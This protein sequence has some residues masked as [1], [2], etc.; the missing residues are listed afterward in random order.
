MAGG[1]ESDDASRRHRDIDFLCSMFDEMDRDLMV[2]IYEQRQRDVQQTLEFLLLQEGQQEEEEEEDNVFINADDDD[3]KNDEELF[4]SLMT[5]EDRQ[6]MIAEMKFY[7]RMKHGVVDDDEYAAAAAADDDD[8]DDEE[9]DDDSTSWEDGLTA[10]QRE[11]ICDLC[12]IFSIDDREAVC[13]VLIA[14]E[15]DKQAAFEQLSLQLDQFVEH[16]QQ[17][18]QQQ[19]KKRKRKFERRDDL[20]GARYGLIRSQWNIPKTTVQL[21]RQMKIEKLKKTF[22]P[23]ASDAAIDAVLRESDDDMRAAARRLKKLYPS[24][25]SE[26]LSSSSTSSSTY[27]RNME[28][29]ANSFSGFAQNVTVEEHRD[30]QLKREKNK[31]AEQGGRHPPFRRHKNH[32]RGMTCNELRNLIY[33]QRNDETHLANRREVHRL[34]QE[35]GGWWHTCLG[36]QQ[37]DL[38]ISPLPIPRDMYNV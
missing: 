20:L 24:V 17:Q 22:A 26:C 18:Q 27:Q 4:S 16:H 34:V 13:A 3:G 7:E 21:A 10:E 31:L 29:V 23:Y 32:Y 11:A 28:Q 19:K 8:D 2:A 35:V 6:I 14:L 9:E 12:A 5:E 30:L 15:F 38:S 1:D 37:S 36:R 33:P 25:N